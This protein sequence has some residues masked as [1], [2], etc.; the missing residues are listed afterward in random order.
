MP[1]SS[2]RPR[3]FSG[4]NRRKARPTSVAFGPQRDVAL[5]PGDAD[6]HHLLALV[7]AARDVADVAHGGGVRARGRSRQ[8]EARHLQPLGE[9][10]QVVV[11]LL[12]RAVL[13]DQLAWAQRVRHHDDGAH[14]GRARGDLAQHQR[15]RLRREAQAAVLLGDEHAEEAVLLD[16]GPD[17]LGDLLV[18]MADPP[19]VDHPAQLVGRAVEE[20]LLLLRQGDRR[21]GAQL[22]PVGLAGEQLGIEADG[23]G[24]QRLLLGGRDPGQDAL[25][26]VEE[27]RDQSRAAQ[28]REWRSPARH[29]HR[30]PGQNAQQIEGRLVPVAVDQPGAP[31][32]NGGGRRTGPAPDRRSAH[33]EHE[34]ADQAQ[35]DEHD[36]CRHEPASRRRQRRPL[37]L[38]ILRQDGYRSTHLASIPKPRSCPQAYDIEKYSRFGCRIS[39]EAEWSGPKRACSRSQQYPKLTFTSTQGVASSACECQFRPQAH[40]YTSDRFLKV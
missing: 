13:L 27:R 28:R 8:R 7:P 33:G 11:L 32:Q 21:D 19:V 36:Y 12:G 24:V 22:L 26:L 25:D 10:R 2:P 4:S 23:A 5:V 17:L 14:V 39:V 37:I 35:Q 15:L 34:D 6:A 1:M 18:L 16:E 38:R 40:W 30:H 29:H 20:R 31:D 3:M 9:A